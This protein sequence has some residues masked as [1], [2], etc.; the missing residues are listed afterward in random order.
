[1]ETLKVGTRVVNTKTGVKAMICGRP[2]HG[3]NRNMM[4]VALEQSTRTEHWPAH[5]IRRRPTR[6]QFEHLGGHYKPPANYPISV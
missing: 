6:E 4:H 2:V 1:M 3:F 5:L